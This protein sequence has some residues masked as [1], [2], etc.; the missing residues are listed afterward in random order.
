MRLSINKILFIPLNTFLFQMKSISIIASLLLTSMAS[1]QQ[2]RDPQLL[3]PNQT[4]LGFGPA[5]AVDGDISCAVWTETSPNYFVWASVSDA[6]GL[7]WSDPIRLDD[8]L[9]LEGKITDRTSVAVDGQ[10][11]YVAWRDDR[12]DGTDDK[13]FFTRSTD[14]GSTWET[15]RHI[16]D[17]YPT[18]ANPIRNLAMAVDSP[19]VYLAARVDTSNGDKIYVVSS[20]DDGATFGPAVYVSD[21]DINTFADAVNVGV[22]AQGSTCHVAWADDRVQAGEDVWYQRSDDAGATWLPA[23]IQVDTNGGIGDAQ[24]QAMFVQA[25]GDLVTVCWQEDDRINTS[26]FIYTNISADGGNT[27]LTS[28]IQVGN[29]DT[30][31]TDVDFNSVAVKNG[32][33]LYAWRDNRTGSDLIYASA[34]SDGGLTFTENVLTQEAGSSDPYVVAGEDGLFSVNFT[35]RGFPQGH[36]VSITNDAGQTFETEIDI[37]VGLIGDV[38]QTAFAYSSLYR[39]FIGAW[40]QDDPGNNQIY[41][42]GFRPQYLGTPTLVGG[43]SVSFIGNGFSASSTGNT[44]LVV[45]SDA[46]GSATTP[47]GR[48]MGIAGGTYFNY[49][50]KPR[51]WISGAIDANGSATTTPIIAPPGLIGTTLQFVGVEFESGTGVVDITEPV[52]AQIQ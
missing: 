18:D 25:D 26:E 13:I 28:D 30:S 45:V 44:M 42:G 19:Y 23:D 33:I 12:F 2:V 38:D 48:N 35:L 17:G 24:T 27:W 10:N 32:T 20:S 11:I 5:V 31:I 3:A 46:V 16:D 8:D 1:A 36:G 34:T 47:D 22:Y 6:R 39:N 37:A 7:N 4:V 29:Y 49:T 51:N 21:F 9:T 14:G 50:T 43:Q 41:V 40:Q 52:S 15:N